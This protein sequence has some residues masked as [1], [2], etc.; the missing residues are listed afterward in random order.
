MNGRVYDPLTAMF[1]SPDPVLYARNW[2]SYNRYAYAYENPFK[3]TDPDGNNPLV[4]TAIALVGG[5]FNLI[6]NISKIDSFEAGLG[7]FLSGAGGAIISAFN[8]AA[9][10]TFT[11]IGNTIM[12]VATGHLPDFS[13]PEQ[14]LDYVG[15]KVLDGFGAAGIGQM[16]KQIAIANGWLTSVQATGSFT[17]LGTSIT[18]DAGISGVEV[19]VTA[20]KTSGSG[21]AGVTGQ[22]GKTI[23]QTATGKGTTV[24][25]KFPQYIN[26]A[27]EIGANRFQVPT[28][29][30]NK[31]TPS[32]QW[33]AN[34][35]FL[36]RAILRGDD[37]IL[38]NK[39]LDI[40]SVTGA[41]R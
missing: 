12:D 31:M 4:F 30:W 18:S 41:F 22:A 9:G 20:T 10:G 3:Y 28:N 21:A 19:T 8:P 15:G 39:V 7:Y 36:D 29:V 14:I 13:K 37:F 33:I 26:L 17:K 38:S 6:S 40:E 27:D 24:L 5:G 16:G 1:F 11:T 34:Q 32:E 2:L 25:G 23:I 35:K